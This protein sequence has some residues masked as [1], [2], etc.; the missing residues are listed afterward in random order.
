M[1]FSSGLNPAWSFTGVGSST[2]GVESVRT[3]GDRDVH[4]EQDVINIAHRMNQAD[5]I[6][7]L[8]VI[9]T[10]VNLISSGYLTI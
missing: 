8:I 5:F 3:N 4:N 6:V 2:P 7:R 1:A 9:F 10:P